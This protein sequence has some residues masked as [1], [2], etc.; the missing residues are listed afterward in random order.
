[1]N[2]NLNCVI[3]KKM[4]RKERK[5]KKKKKYFNYLFIIKFISY[6]IL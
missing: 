4:R 1:M 5:K 3:I 2:Y 6:L